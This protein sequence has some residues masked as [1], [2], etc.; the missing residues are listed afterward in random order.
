[1]SRLYGVR[2]YP[3][4]HVT[5]VGLGPITRGYGGTT[6]VL[7]LDYITKKE[8]KPQPYNKH[9]KEEELKQGKGYRLKSKSLMQAKRCLT[10]EKRPTENVERRIDACVVNRQIGRTNRR[11]M[12]GVNNDTID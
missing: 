8:R 5:A 7:D 12:D 3:R 4:F 1:M 6:V 11:R 10:L 2:Y 9:E